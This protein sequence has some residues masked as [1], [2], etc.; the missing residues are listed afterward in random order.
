VLGGHI[1]ILVNNAGLYPSPPTT[2]LSD[3]AVG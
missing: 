1:D 2:E 3:D